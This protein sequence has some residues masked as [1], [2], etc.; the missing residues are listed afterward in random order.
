MAANFS[1]SWDRGKGEGGRKKG[2]GCCL[3]VMAVEGEGEREL[4]WGGVEGRE[5]E[6]IGCPERES[7][8]EKNE[9][10]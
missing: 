5:N 7:G 9:E 4:A 10:E 1:G 6:E 8:R 2:E 3:R